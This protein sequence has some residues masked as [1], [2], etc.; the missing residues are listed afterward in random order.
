M[1]KKVQDRKE[2]GGKAVSRLVVFVLI[3]AAL[4]ANSI[5]RHSVYALEPMAMG[6]CTTVRYHRPPTEGPATMDYAYYSV[7][8]WSRVSL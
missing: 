1:E 5:I 8:F 6:D 4:P 7:L 2:K 3:P